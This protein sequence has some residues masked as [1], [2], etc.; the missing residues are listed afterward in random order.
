MVKSAATDMVKQAAKALMKVKEKKK[1][2][3]EAVK[4]QRAVT[5]K[6]KPVQVTA[7]KNQAPGSSSNG[8]DASKLL[9]TKTVKS[10]QTDKKAKAAMA[11][12]V[13][14][15]AEK[16]AVLLLKNVVKQAKKD[17]VNFLEVP[18]DE[19]SMSEEPEGTFVE[20]TEQEFGEQLEDIQAQMEKV[21][22]GH[23]ASEPEVP[24][25][26]GIVLEKGPHQHDSW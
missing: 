7:I 12:A 10:K 18:Q 20:E 9:T 5:Q 8:S 22:E 4:L 11:K 13:E 16:K 1:A 24:S 3:K 26:S 19:E 2:K 17:E 23:N 21:I 15:S 14:K 6:K 25:L